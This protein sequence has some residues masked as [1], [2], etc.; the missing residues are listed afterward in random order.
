MQHGVRTT[1]KKSRL[2]VYLLFILAYIVAEYT[3]WLT[4]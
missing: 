3:V 1:L 2:D 4:S